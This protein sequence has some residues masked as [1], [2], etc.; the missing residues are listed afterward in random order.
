[1]PLALARQRL[2]TWSTSLPRSYYPSREQRRARRVLAPAPFSLDLRFNETMS[3]LKIRDQRHRRSGFPTR[4]ARRSRRRMVIFQW[5][6]A[7]VSRRAMVGGGGGGGGGGRAGEFRSA[8]RSQYKKGGRPC[9]ESLGDEYARLRLRG[10]ALEVDQGDAGK[11]R[12]PEL[13]AATAGLQQRRP[14]K[15][16]LGASIVG[17]SSLV[18]LRS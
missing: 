15:C 8:V 16:D 13:A 7:S 5:K 3:G 6:N 4:G 11:A 14:R 12:R 17:H 2:E 10:G 9:S 18:E 1:M